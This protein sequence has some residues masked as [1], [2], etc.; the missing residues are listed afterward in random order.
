MDSHPFL[1]QYAIFILKAKQD[2]SLVREV[3]DNTNVAPEIMLFHIQQG[4]EKLI[5]ALF[6]LYSVRFPK[7]HDLD[8]LVEL[9]QDS[10][11]DLPLD[12]EKLTELTPYAVEWRYAVLHDDLHDI[13]GMLQQAESFLEFVESCAQARR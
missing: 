11:I 2:F 8:E 13:S 10:G 7:T 1:E 3:M 6:C 4:V 5:K 12:M 9:A